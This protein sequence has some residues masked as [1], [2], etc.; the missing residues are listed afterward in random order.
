MSSE[1]CK[2][3]ENDVAKTITSYPN[4]HGDSLVKAEIR[5][6]DLGTFHGHVLL[7][8]RQTFGLIFEIVSDNMKY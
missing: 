5:V 3:D 2:L 6:P 7:K 8:Y 1:L 4:F